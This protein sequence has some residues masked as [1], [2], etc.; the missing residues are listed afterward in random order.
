[1]GD[2]FKEQIVKRRTTFK[3]TAIRISLVLSVILIFVATVLVLFLQGIGIIITAAATFG[4]MYLMSFLSVEYEYVYTNGELDI[5]AIYNKSRRK[6]LFSAVVKDFEIMAHI[7]DKNHEHTLTTAQEVKDFSSGLP[8]P[9]TYVFLTIIN[10]KK[11]KVIIEPNEKM[12]K[13]ISG[14]ISR[15]KLFL[16]PGVILIG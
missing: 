15:R 1:M 6:R 16:R 14:G 4:A 10:G 11:T 7:D 3:D 5:D 8:G 9:D 2:V 12:L 13:A